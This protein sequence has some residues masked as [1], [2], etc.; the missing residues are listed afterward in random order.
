MADLPPDDVKPQPQPQQPFMSPPYPDP[1]NPILHKILEGAVTTF[2]S[3]QMSVAGAIGSAASI[4]WAMGHVEGED[5]CTGC[6]YRLMPSLPRNV[7]HGRCLRRSVDMVTKQMEDHATLLIQQ[8]EAGFSKMPQNVAD[9]RILL[10]QVRHA[11]GVL[12]VVGE[13]VLNKR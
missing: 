7:P 5:G 2:E 3:G 10:A 13:A 4:A 8:I 9:L 12:G 11:V 1:K 6:S